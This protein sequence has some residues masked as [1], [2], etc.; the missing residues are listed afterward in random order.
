MTHSPLPGSFSEMG[1]KVN[2]LG[3]F[4]N[5]GKVCHRRNEEKL[6]VARNI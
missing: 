5:N 1:A 4:R 6:I 2:S 3:P